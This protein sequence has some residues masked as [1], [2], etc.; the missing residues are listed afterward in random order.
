[1]T[2]RQRL[3]EME[4]I[5]KESKWYWPLKIIFLIIFFII[6][7]FL[8]ATEIKKGVEEYRKS[9]NTE[10]LLKLIGNEIE[11]N[12]RENAVATYEI[13]KMFSDDKEVKNDNE[14]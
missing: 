13:I 14:R 6:M 8:N 2:K 4:K 12:L 11:D 3:K 5:V 9:E 10:K 1:M 7:C